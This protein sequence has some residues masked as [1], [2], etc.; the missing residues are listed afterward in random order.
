MMQSQYYVKNYSNTNSHFVI[1]PY[2]TS[3]SLGNKKNF[4]GSTIILYSR[5]R[6][7]LLQ[8]TSTWK[9]FRL[10][11]KSLVIYSGADYADK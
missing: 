8:L 6:D 2:H 3:I 10:T 9:L 4:I 7:I 1:M 5:K 11:P